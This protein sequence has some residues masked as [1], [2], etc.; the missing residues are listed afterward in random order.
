MSPADKV[1]DH[2]AETAAGGLGGGAVLAAVLGADTTTVAAIA[3]AAGVLPTII[4][5]LDRQ[6]GIRGLVRRIWTGRST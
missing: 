4:T 6:H 5:W 1:L 3:A 2:P